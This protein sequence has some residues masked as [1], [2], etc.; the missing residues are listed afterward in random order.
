M[1]R[2]FYDKNGAVLEGK[3]DL[4]DK[5]YWC[6]EGE[7]KEHA[8]V[9]LFGCYIGYR[10]NP[11]KTSD[12]HVPD[13]I[14]NL[15]ILADLKSQHTPFFKAQELYKMEPTY[16]VVFNLK[17][18]DRYRSKYPSIDIIFHVDWIAVKALIDGRTYEVSE[19]KGIYRISFQ[20][21]DSILNTAPIHYYKQRENDTKGNARASYLIDIRNSDFEKLH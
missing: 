8:F 9:R 11:E 3:H 4:Q 7:E 16:T 20:A 21:L 14:S 19:Y 1:E 15:N 17:D 12:P 5:L 6:K 13:L 10:L 2:T 18:R